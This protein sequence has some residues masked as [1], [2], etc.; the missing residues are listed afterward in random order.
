MDAPRSLKT[1]PAIPSRI[2]S[3]KP[4]VHL[5]LF[6]I[7]VP[8]LFISLSTVKSRGG[9]FRGYLIAGER[10]LAGQFLYEGSG[11]ATNVTWPPF[12]ALFITPF[13]LLARIHLPLTQMLWYCLNIT[14]FFWTLHLWCKLAYGKPLGGFDERRDLSL[15]SG[16]VLIPVLLTVEPLLRNF[17][18]LQIN[19]MILFLMSLGFHRLSEGRERAAGFWFGLAAAIKAFPVVIF[20]YLLLRKRLR[21][22]AFMGLW[23]LVLTAL[24]V[25]RYGIPSYLEHLRTW[26]HLSLSGGYPVGSLNQSVYAMV[27]RWIASDPFLLME[28]RL[29][30]PAPED[31][32]TLVATWVFRGL[33]ALFLAGFLYIAGRGR[34]LRPDVEGAYWILLGMVFSPVAWVHY[35]VLIFPAVFVLWRELS[36]RPDPTLRWLFWGAAFLITGLNVLG[37]IIPPVRGVAHCLLSSMTLGALVLLVALLSILGRSAGS[38]RRELAA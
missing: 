29:P 4:W 16:A 30:P 3:R 35:W 20:F 6:L 24:P 11:V 34:N 25:F 22:A 1:D 9:D 28:T 19:V 27:A 36:R 21:A 12:F 37:R 18:Q 5:L 38:D 15:M 23:G 13:A 26:I 7:V 32:R 8:N 17:V 10:F 2:R 14:L 33:F 31:P